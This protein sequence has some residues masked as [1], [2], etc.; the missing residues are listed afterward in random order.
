M[1]EKTLII[2]LCE[3]RGHSRT[4]AGFKKNLLDVF[5]AD[6]ALCIADNDREDKDNPFY[7]H[8]R[9]IWSCPEFDDWGEGFEQLMPDL[10]PDWRRCAVIGPQWMGGV[11]TEPN[12]PGSGGIIFY[13]RIF[14]REMLE[15]DQLVEA[16]DRFILTRSDFMFDLPHPPPELLN[17]QFIWIPDGERYDGYPDRH[18][19]CP[20]SDIVKA[21]SVADLFKENP[22]EVIRRMQSRE[23]NPESVLKDHFER[24]GLSK[25]IRKMPYIMYAIREEGGHTRWTM[26]EYDKSLGLYV[27]YPGE[28]RKSKLALAV[29]SGGKWT[30]AKFSYLIG[31]ESVRD[32]LVDNYPST[33][34]GFLPVHR[35]VSKL[36]R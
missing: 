5:G 7:T 20:S 3:T 8:A 35:W 2:V 21:L 11:R 24:I 14:L 29:L 9:Y 16:Y 28:L 22:D 23:W 33:V 18:L 32:Y 10:H 4:F 15:R 6:L 13:F 36:F 34:Q 30:A 1:A 17:N 26:G 19:I 27:K 31:R 25:R 12:H